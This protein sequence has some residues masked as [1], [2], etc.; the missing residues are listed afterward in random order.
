[1]ERIDKAKLLEWLNN[2]LWD[3]NL[4]PP[5][6]IYH[7]YTDLKR[8]IECGTFDPDPKVEKQKQD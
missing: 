3:G 5:P 4:P 2:R 1:M 7:A 6:G 8:H